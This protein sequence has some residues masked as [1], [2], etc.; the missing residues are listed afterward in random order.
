MTVA[1]Y[2]PPDSLDDIPNERVML[3]KTDFDVVSTLRELGHQV[4][5]LGL[6]DDLAPLRAAID[7]HDPHVVFN[8]LEHFRGKAS[9]VPYVLGYLELLGVRYTGCNPVGMMFSSDKARQR[10]ILRHHRIPTPDFFIVSRGRAPK[11]P[12]RLDYPLIVKSNTE[13][14]STG[15]AEAS[16]VTTD[17]KLAQR[18]EYVHQTIGTDAIVERYIHGRELYCAIM[19]NRRL[20]TFPLWELSM[21]KLRDG[22]P[23]I[24]TE[25]IKWDAKR[26][27]SVGAAIGQ[28]DLDQR[29]AAAIARACKRAYKAL[30][31]NGY[32]RFDVRLTD[33][34]RF[35][36]IEGNPNPQL[37]F[38]DEF[39][40]A[41]KAG[42]ITYPDLL[43]RILRLAMNP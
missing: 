23:A 22:A 26:Q 24:A 28:A 21:T 6:D 9:L 25:R 34:G 36:I 7:E 32:A 18:V 19:G 31:Q 14:G 43:T 37:S 42:G 15:I 29:T 16:V 5:V 1:G 11:R 35:S 17:E 39:A 40:D 4:I 12:P 27:D 33:D 13:H 2:E 10:K 8:L 30:E 38:D 41:A 20:T 3:L